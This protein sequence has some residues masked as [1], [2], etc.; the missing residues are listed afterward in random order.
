MA[1]PPI[2][3]AQRLNIMTR[4]EYKFK[5]VDLDKTNSVDFFEF[6]YLGFLMTQVSVVAS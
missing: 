4:L 3:G 5:Q 2:D 6:I 1:L